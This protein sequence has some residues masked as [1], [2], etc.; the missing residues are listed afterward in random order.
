[1]KQCHKIERG[2]HDISLEILSQA[3]LE[4]ARQAATSTE[5]HTLTIAPCASLDG[6]SRV[7][8]ANTM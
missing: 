4:I 8:C 2:E 3:G 1:M 7:P 6:N 5:R